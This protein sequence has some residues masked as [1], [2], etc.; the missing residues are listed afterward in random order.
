[1]LWLKLSPKVKVC[2]LLGMVACSS[3]W[4]KSSSSIIIIINYYFHQPLL[5]IIINHH[6]TT[7]PTRGKNSLVVLVINLRVRTVL[8]GAK[9]GGNDDEG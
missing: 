2:G 4:L 9:N 3:L 7:K 1:M 5:I 6:T 8:E